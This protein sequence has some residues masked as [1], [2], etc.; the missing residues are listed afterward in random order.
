MLFFLQE[1]SFL[2]NISLSI[3]R[4]INR[5]INN[6]PKQ[7]KVPL[8]ML[9]A[10]NLSADHSTPVQEKQSIFFLNTPVQLKL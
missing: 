4:K 10:I 3:M 9:L 2:R 6:E 8:S 7:K 5:L 1:F